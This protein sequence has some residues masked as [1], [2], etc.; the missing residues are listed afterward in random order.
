MISNA[1]VFHPHGVDVSI[2]SK[3]R[4]FTQSNQITAYTSM[5]RKHD[6]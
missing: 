1:P 6:D 4:G 5:G 2:D 3:K